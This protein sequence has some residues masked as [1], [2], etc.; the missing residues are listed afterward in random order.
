MTQFTAIELDFINDHFIRVF[1]LK[2][3][4]KLQKG[5]R[6]ER[7]EYR[8]TDLEKEYK[9]YTDKQNEILLRAEQLKIVH[10]DSVVVQRLDI[11]KLY[12]PIAMDPA[13]D[14]M[15]KHESW[16]ARVLFISEVDCGDDIKEKKKKLIKLNDIVIYNAEV[17]YSL[18]LRWYEYDIYVMHI[19]NVI[20]VDSWFDCDR[21]YREN[22]E[23]KIGMPIENF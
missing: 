10:E 6:M 9:E 23:K 15:R 18:N 7:K 17:P 19:N 3:H 16:Y 11:N 8:K 2:T 14:K 22:L 4:L 21:L 12:T 20:C 1:G 13:G 5:G